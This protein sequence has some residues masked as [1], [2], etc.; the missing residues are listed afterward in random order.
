MAQHRVITEGF[1]L[2]NGWTA[3]TGV[4]AASVWSTTEGTPSLV[5]GR[6]GGQCVRGT[7]S[8]SFLYRPIPQSS[9]VSMGAAVRLE[10]P[11]RGR[12]IFQFRSSAGV[13]LTLSQTATGALQISRGSTVLATTSDIEVLPIDQWAYVE[14]SAAISPTNGTT[15]VSIDGFQISDLTLSDVNTQNQSNSNVD[16]VYLGVGSITNASY[17]YYDDLYVEIDGTTHVGEGR[18]W[19]G[20]V[21]SDVESDFT[22]STGSSNYATI[23]EVPVSA[24]DYNY[25]DALGARDLFNVADLDFYPAE[26]YGVQIT[27][28]ASKDE[29]GSR[30]IKNV[31]VSGVTEEQGSQFVLAL[32]SNNW[33]NDFWAKNPDTGVNWTISDVNALKIGYEITS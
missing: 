21:V 7:T 2:Y 28:N 33:H 10:A 25:S 31:L 16:F 6:F 15:S 26:I 8:G 27:V 19:V 14:F 32:S 20:Q 5:A 24:T 9:M 23:D 17:S 13:Q 29:A 11:L 22:P 3:G 4:G 1:D 12:N 30:A 18:M